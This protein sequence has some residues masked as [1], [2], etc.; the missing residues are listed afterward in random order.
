MHEDFVDEFCDQYWDGLSATPDDARNLDECRS[1]ITALVDAMLLIESD[2]KEP[3]PDTVVHDGHFDDVAQQIVKLLRASPHVSTV[4]L[5]QR[6]SVELIAELA[7]ML[8]LHEEQDARSVL[9]RLTP[10]TRLTDA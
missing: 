1:I 8:A 3:D 7:R 6:A 2:L 4:G 10:E 5:L 9:R